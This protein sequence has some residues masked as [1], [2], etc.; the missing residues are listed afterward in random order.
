MFKVMTLIFCHQRK[1]K[2][3]F[4]LSPEEEKNS[5]VISGVLLASP[6]YKKTK[7]AEREYLQL[8]IGVNYKE[9]DRNGRNYPAN[10]KFLVFFWDKDIIEYSRKRNLVKLS[11][12]TVEGALQTSK[13]KS[14]R[15]PKGD[16]IM[17]KA[18]RLQVENYSETRREIIQLDEKFNRSIEEDE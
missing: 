11:K 6:I 1:F 16:L 18:R 7:I 10:S 15:Y 2:M 17:F 8:I 9:Q 13:S 12:V 3:R 5:L 14:N 4:D